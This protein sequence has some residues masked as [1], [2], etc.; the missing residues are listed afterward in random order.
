MNDLAKAN[1][2]LIRISPMAQNSSLG[3]QFRWKMRSLR[4][5]NHTPTRGANIRITG[6]LIQRTN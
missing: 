2:C 3:I 1:L 6:E 5:F 4:T